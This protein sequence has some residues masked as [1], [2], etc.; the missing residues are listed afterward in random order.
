MVGKDILHS[1]I[2]FR[3]KFFQISQRL[4]NFQDKV[5]IQTYKQNGVYLANENWIHLVILNEMQYQT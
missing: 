2:C 5:L 3:K 4:R 1:I